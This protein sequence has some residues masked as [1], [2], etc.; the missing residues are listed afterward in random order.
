MDT[1]EVDTYVA[2]SWVTESSVANT[3][4]VPKYC[5]YLNLLSL[6][7]GLQHLYAQCS[8]PTPCYLCYLQPALSGCLPPGRLV[9]S[10]KHRQSATTVWQSLA[11]LGQDMTRHQWVTCGHG[12]SG[13][14]LWLEL[15]RLTVIPT[16]GLSPANRSG[17]VETK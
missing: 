3:S 7:S 11:V 8:V 10:L 4:L 9:I 12:P 17:W 13:R 2:D 6:G 1:S 5:N 16:W 14:Q 15:N